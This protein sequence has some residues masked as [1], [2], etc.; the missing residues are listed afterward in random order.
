MQRGNLLLP[1]CFI[2]N[3]CKTIM[4]GTTYPLSSCNLSGGKRRLTEPSRTSWEVSK[5]ENH[6]FPDRVRR[7][8]EGVTIFVRLPRPSQEETDDHRRTI[9]GY[10]PAAGGAVV[11]SELLPN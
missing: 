2:A 6:G 3:S 8:R 4:A 7:E 10:N 1:I 9:A 11:A 5:C